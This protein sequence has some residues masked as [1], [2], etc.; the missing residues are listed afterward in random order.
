MSVKGQIKETT[1]YLE[2]EAGEMLKKKKMAN[3]GRALRNEGRIE[4]GKMP[5]VTPPGSG[6]N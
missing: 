2:E 1:G 3:K 4:D 6:S 5:K